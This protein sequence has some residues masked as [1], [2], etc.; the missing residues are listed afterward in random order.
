MVSPPPL[1]FATPALGVRVDVPD[2]ARPAV[3]TALRTFPPIEPGGPIHLHL[4]VA[5]TPEGWQATE[6]TG[7]THDR[8]SLP[9][10]VSAVVSRL[11]E[12]HLAQDA[13]RVHLHAAALGTPTGVV[14]LVGHSGAGKSTLATHLLRRGLSYLTDEMVAVDADGQVHG[15]PKPLTLKYGSRH[16]ADP[17]RDRLGLH[18]DPAQ[19]QRWEVPADAL[20]PVAPVGPHPVRLVVLPWWDGAAPADPEI[21]DLD[22]PEALVALAANALDVDR[23]PEQALV[24]LGA[25][26]GAP[27]HRL[28]HRDAEAVAD[29][30][31]DHTAATSAVPP[32]EVELVPPPAQ[33]AGLRR[34]TPGVLLGHRAVVWDPGGS[35]MVVLNAEGTELWRSLTGSEPPPEDADVET[36]RFLQLLA[37]EGLVAGP[38]P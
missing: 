35:R 28:R 16:L 13:G 23:A 19:G 26:A 15:Y 20:G 11:N 34:V 25:V 10:L 17:V 14:L 29:W 5:R 18:T 37:R 8:P 7:P 1:L 12:A 24:A 22:R 38:V 31:L 36:R 2:D 9:E 6:A 4:V 21:E 3:A 30:V 33:S 27:T 32:G